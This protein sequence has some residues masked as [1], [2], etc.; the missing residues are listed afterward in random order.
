MLKDIDYKTT[1]R[2]YLSDPVADFYVPSFANSNRFDRGVGYFTLSSIVDMLYLDSGLITF[3]KNKGKIRIITSPNFKEEDSKIIQQGSEKALKISNKI[4]EDEIE[5]ALDAPTQKAMDL[6]ANLIALN[7]LEIKI[8]VP[9]NGGLYHEKIGF[10]FDSNNDVVYFIGS[11]NQ[12]TSANT[13]NVESLFVVKSWE[14]SKTIEEEYWFFDNLWNNQLDGIIVYSFPDALKSKIIKTFKIN[15][16]LEK[17]IKDYEKKTD[18]N[19]II[20]EQKLRDY[21]EKAIKQFLNQKKHLFEMATG[22]GKT[23]TAVMAIKK[24]IE[25]KK[26]LVIIIVP[27]TALI[28]QWRSEI[29]KLNVKILTFSSLSN[30]NFYEA[31]ADYQM[32]N[33]S[34]IMI[35]TYDTYFSNTNDMSNFFRNQKDLIFVADEVHNITPNY[36]KKLPKKAEYKLGLSATPERYNINETKDIYNYFLQQGSSSFKY[37]IE[38]AIKAGYLAHYNY[39]IFKAYLTEEESKTYKDLSKNLGLLL[40]Q[41]P[42]D[43]EKIKKIVSLRSLILKKAENK[44]DILRDIINENKISFTNSVVY[45]GQGT[46]NEETIID[47]VTKIIGEKYEVQQYVSKKTG[48]YRKE[49][50][51]KFYANKLDALIAI[52]CLDEGVDIPKLS[53]IIITSSDG[54]IRQTV[55]RRGRVLRKCKETGKDSADIYD[56]VILPFP[57]NSIADGKS[58][59]I[60]ELKRLKE[61]NSLADNKEINDKLINMLENKYNIT[62]YDYL[63]EK[64]IMEEE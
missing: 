23:F 57:G 36:Y 56:F 6:I 47:S 19:E 60:S 45:C 10:F 52:R 63:I 34:L 3:L 20:V 27:F 38:E 24:I 50:L 58:I 51:D 13:V 30:S 7:I 42:R 1:Y 16:S 59:V 28:E 62:K 35:S 46:N 64:N 14:D 4:I 22:T 54:A 26:S 8:A 5:K 41:N 37:G 29:S 43:F 48:T 61:Y 40:N 49:I 53:K 12:T 9:K 55:Q 11:N 32:S 44:L 17:S 18:N 25:N 31:S 2:T 39:F 33:D 21:Q 15:N